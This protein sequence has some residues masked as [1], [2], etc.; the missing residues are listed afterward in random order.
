MTTP[1]PVIRLILTRAEVESMSWRGLARC[2]EVDPDL[3]FPE[4]GGNA[5]ARV[6]K[7]ICRMCPVR[8]PCLDYAL[9]NGEMHGIWGATSPEDRER[10][11]REEKLAAGQAAA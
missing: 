4:K 6:A 1:A 5:R 11:R 9:R 2:A 8:R 7:R 10:I 3:W